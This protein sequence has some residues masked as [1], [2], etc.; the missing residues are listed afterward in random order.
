MIN[1]AKTE[2]Q[3]DIEAEA[4]AASDR[5]IVDIFTKKYG[6]AFSKYKLSKAFLR[7]ARDHSVDDLSADEIANCSNLITAINNAL[8]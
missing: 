7:W 5:P 6:N 4:T 2:L 3:W 1:V 8:K